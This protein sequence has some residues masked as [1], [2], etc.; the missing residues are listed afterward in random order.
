LFALCLCAALA[1][2]AAPPSPSS[3]TAAVARLIDQLG[4]E[5]TRPAAEKRLRALGE[6]VL[7]ALE[8]ATKSHSDPDVRLRA[9]VL[10]SAIEKVQPRE[11]RTIDIHPGCV[12]V[13][14]ISPDGK[15]V[16]SSA[17]GEVRLWDLGTGKETVRLE[18]QNGSSH[19][20]AW[21][22]DGKHVLAG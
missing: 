5:D 9:A 19:A 11:L 3:A 1:P 14:A 20:A 10:A 15:R 18:G 13:F 7:P 2:G 17:N 12:L 8:E 22:S 6:D 21:T 16:V 4:E